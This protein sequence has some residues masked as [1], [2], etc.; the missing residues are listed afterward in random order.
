M[1]ASTPQKTAAGRHKEHSA[2]R[3]YDAEQS[4]QHATTRPRRRQTAETTKAVHVVTGRSSR[5]GP[6]N[7]LPGDAEVPADPRACLA[8]EVRTHGSPRCIEFKP[9]PIR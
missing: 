1:P 4:R 5:N 2:Q 3:R 7:H 6:L 9:E 8:V